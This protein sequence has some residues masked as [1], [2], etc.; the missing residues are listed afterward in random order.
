[1]LAAAD[2]DGDS[3]KTTITIVVEN[4]IDKRGH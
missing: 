4:R 1:M 2:G 3:N